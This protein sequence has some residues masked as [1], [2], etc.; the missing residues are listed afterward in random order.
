M[1]IIMF[2]DFETSGLPLFD[3]P[4][5]DPGQPHI[6]QA[7]AVLV[8]DADRKIVGQFEAVAYPLGWDIPDE[9]AKIHGIT[10]E[11]AWQTGIQEEVITQMVHQF[12]KVAAVR[13]AHN[14]SFDARIMRIAMMRSGLNA[15]DLEEYKSAPAECTQ[16]LSTPILNLPPTDRMLAAGRRGAK[17]ANLTEAFEHFTGRKM[18]GAHGAM[19]DCLA[20]MEVYFAIKQGAAS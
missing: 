12:W 14:E 2:Y 11:R 1:S 8:D 3:K 20:C 10:T 17:S 13:V 4:S 16:R 19:A 7:A 5:E 9:V 6:V 15:A 18:V